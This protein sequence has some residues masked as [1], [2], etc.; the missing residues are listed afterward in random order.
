MTVPLFGQG[1]G[2]PVQVLVGPKAAARNISRFVDL[3]N[4][5]LTVEDTGNQA[6]DTCSF[7]VLDVR[8]VITHIQPE[9]RV[10]VKQGQKSLFRGFIRTF[11]PVPFTNQN[12][13]SVQCVG[14]SSLIDKCIIPPGSAYARA[15]DES[16]RARILWLLT[17]F[18]QPFLDLASN[19]FTKVQVLESLMEDQKFGSLTLRQAI[20]QVLGASSESANYYFDTAGRL[21]TFDDDHPESDEAPYEVITTQTPGATQVAPTNLQV[22][23]D[24]TELVNYYIVRGKNRAGSGQF[25]NEESI[26]LYGRRQA[27]IDGPN[28]DTARKARRLGR[29][30][31]HDT[32]DPMRRGSFTVDHEYTARNGQLWEPGQQVYVTAPG[33]GWLHHGERIIR[34]TTKYIDPVGSREVD[35]EFGAMRRTFASGTG[36]DQ[37]EPVGYNPSVT[38]P[39]WEGGEPWWEDGHVST[40]PRTEDAVTWHL[41]DDYDRPFEGPSTDVTQ[42]VSPTP[43]TPTAPFGGS[44][45]ASLTRTSGVSPGTWG[46]DG[47]MFIETT[48]DLMHVTYVITGPSY[49]VDGTLTSADDTQRGPWVNHVLDVRIHWR[50]NRL[51]AGAYVAVAWQNDRSQSETYQCTAYVKLDSSG[52]SLFI[53]RFFYA[54]TSIAKTLTAATWY[55]TRFQWSTGQVRMRTWADTATEPTTWDADKPAT[56]TLA[57]APAAAILNVLIG[58]G[59]SNSPSV[60]VEIDEV[61]Y[62][63]FAPEGTWLTETLAGDGSTTT[64][65]LGR[66][67]QQIRRVTVDGIAVDNTVKVTTVIDG[68]TFI[69]AITFDQAPSSDAVIVIEYVAGP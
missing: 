11:T 29:A 57:Q 12:R 42:D 26:D 23:W 8:R 20:E 16:D 28:S 66:Y 65:V 31:L 10:I 1:S 24:T 63:G 5:P 4:A 27:F 54:D 17:T 15:K 58:A 68:Q 56:V 35:V 41:I 61:K 51:C 2:T 9:A 52:T 48:G 47:S 53:D 7:E 50:I 38:I 49:E 45:D 3:E 14:L 13:V 25:S 55:Y 43:A 39:G 46:F 67:A 32:K 64:F 62:S 34:V 59:D 30:A 69:R 36:I 6:D 60:R 44:W 21:H 40:P 18:G 37:R 33:L 22:T 19:D